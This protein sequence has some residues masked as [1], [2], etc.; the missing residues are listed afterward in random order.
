MSAP[1]LTL[2]AADREG[3]RR[4]QQ[5]AYA[6]AEAI[7]AG[8]Q[9]GVTER[10]VAA[11]MNAWL[12]DHGAGCPRP[13]LVWFGPRTAF[14]G[15]MGIA[16]LRGFNPAFFPGNARLEAGMPF[17]L[18]LIIKVCIISRQTIRTMVEKTKLKINDT[19]T[20]SIYLY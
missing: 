2:R 7:N 10:E 16:P 8:L 1:S 15:L 3:S 9:P 20:E 19:K 12:A 17:I 4:A 11:R 13:P 14:R 5:L 18:I 6:C